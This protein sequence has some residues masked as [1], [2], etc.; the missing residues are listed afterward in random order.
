MLAYSVSG[1]SPQHRYSSVS[2]SSRMISVGVFIYPVIT[3][4][5]HANHTHD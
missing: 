4:S 1:L 5:N 3:L 2:A